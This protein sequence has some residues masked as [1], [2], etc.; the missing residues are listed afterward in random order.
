VGIFSRGILKRL[1]ARIYFADEPANASDPIL[2]LVPADRRHTLLAK[3]DSAKPGLY[4]FDIHLQGTD[5]TV[6]FDA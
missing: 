6:F 5:E 4:R 3:P 2:G 1:F